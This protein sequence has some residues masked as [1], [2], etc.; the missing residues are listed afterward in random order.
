MGNTWSRSATQQPETKSQ[1][2]AS[3]AA[4]KQAT[5]AQVGVKR[6]ANEKDVSDPAAKKSKKRDGWDNRKP[7]NNKNE[8][9]KQ[10]TLQARPEH[11]GPREPRIPKKKVALL[12][13]FNG[14]GYQGMQLNPGCL[15]IESVIFEAMV[16]ANAISKDN[17]DDPKKSAWMRAARTDKGVHAA[18]NLISLKMQI[19]EDYDVVE[20][21][22]SFLPPQIRV[23]GYVPCIRSFHAKNL[24]DSRIYEYLLPTCAFMAPESKIL[25]DTP[26]FEDDLVI[27]NNNVVDP[28][29]KYATRSTPELKQQR[30]DYRATQQ[31]LDIFTAAMKSFEGTH[32]FHNYTN[33]KS[34]K[35]RSSYRYIISINVSKPLY[36]DGSE[37][38]S[39]KLHGQSFVLHQIRKMISMGMLIT[40]SNTP[41]SLIPKTF[42]ENCINVPKAPALGLLLER[43][44]FQ[45]YNDKMRGKSNQVERDIVDFDLFKDEIDAF[46]NDWI[47]K[48][49]FEAENQ[50]DVF[51]GY[52]TSLDAHLGNDYEYLNPEGVIPE[53]CLVS[54][55][56]NRPTKQELE[57]EEQEQEQDD[58]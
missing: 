18:G 37:W 24:C 42:E 29:V 19:P 39:I 46:K 30:H 33:R 17:A 3:T 26:T 51:D 40:R 31:Q 16:K 27:S 53:S 23:W 43:P 10:K 12:V 6:L 41:I 57:D 5:S 34:F 56:Y 7:K 54:T 11:L 1:A 45:V 38:V 13:G 28:V 50:E 20:R 47:Y 25:T 8:T 36:I 21:I 15:S 4:E 2:V 48:K 58:E 32:N 55:K 35:D 52:L 49:I 9:K 14:T 44:I 22:N